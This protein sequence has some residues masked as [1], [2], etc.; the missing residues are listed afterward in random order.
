MGGVW[1]GD[2]CYGLEAWVRRMRLLNGGQA[3]AGQMGWGTLL[4]FVTEFSL[5]D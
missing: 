4:N 2:D 5:G 1:R 3:V